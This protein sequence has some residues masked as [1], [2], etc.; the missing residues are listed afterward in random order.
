M[1]ARRDVRICGT[2]LCTQ[3]LRRAVLIECLAH[4]DDLPRLIEKRAY[5]FRTADFPNGNALSW[6]QSLNLIRAA[7]QHTCSMPAWYT[8]DES[9]P[10]LTASGRLDAHGAIEFDAVWQSVPADVSHIV[11]D[12]TQVTYLSSIGIR[13]LVLI[14]KMLRARH[15]NLVLAGMTKFVSGVLETTGLLREFEVAADLNAARQRVRQAV[16]QNPQCFERTNGGRHY[17]FGSI[18][19][20]P[21]FIDVWGSFETLSSD[22]RT[23]VAVLAQPSS[24]APVSATAEELGLAFGYGALGDTRSWT[25]TT[26]GRSSSLGI[27]PQSCLETETERRISFSP[28]GRSKWSWPYRKPR[29]SADRRRSKCN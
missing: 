8:R 19:D 16:K 21:C 24:P 23:V 22:P 15:G 11:I 4:R 14:E 18:T 12:L 17:R 1:A 28:I 3:A 20:E 7:I 25:R 9:I 27:S 26:A 29:D 6:R 13:S 5:R 10:V 2:L